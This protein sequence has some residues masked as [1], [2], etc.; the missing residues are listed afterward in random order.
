MEITYKNKT[1]V[2]DPELAIDTGALVVK[3]ILPLHSGDVYKHAKYCSQLLVNVAYGKD[4][5]QLL[6]MGCSPNS[7]DFFRE[8]HTIKEIENE[9]RKD[10]YEF[11]R[12]ISGEVCRLVEG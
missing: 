3:K 10:D 11:V 7:N 2:L 12:N 9:L 6:G 1:Y 8:V 4:E 5:W